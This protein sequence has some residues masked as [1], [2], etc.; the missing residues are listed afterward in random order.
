M[1]LFCLS[2]YSGTCSGALCESCYLTSLALRNEL[3]PCLLVEIMDLKSKIKLIENVS[4]SHSF[5]IGG[6]MVC[7]LVESLYEI[8]I[9]SFP[10]N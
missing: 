8:E 9:L 2:P 7:V 1:F 3:F 5:L 10:G 6:W 4:F